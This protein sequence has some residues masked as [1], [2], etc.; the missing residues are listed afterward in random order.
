MSF[1]ARS[2]LFQVVSGPFLLVV[3]RFKSF[4]TRCRSSQV[5]SGCFRSFRVLVSTFILASHNLMKAFLVY[6]CYLGILRL[7]VER[8]QILTLS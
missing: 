1:L 2:R 4:L 8:N 3:G 7:E 6:H 5:V